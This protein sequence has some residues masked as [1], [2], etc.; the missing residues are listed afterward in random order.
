MLTAKAKPKTPLTIINKTLSDLRFV[1]KNPLTK[2]ML[3]QLGNFAYL[4]GRVQEAITVG[5]YALAAQ[6]CVLLLVSQKFSSPDIG[7]ARS[8][9]SR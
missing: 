8:E 9:D 1:A 5:D 2:L 4:R 7:D 3:A 6:L